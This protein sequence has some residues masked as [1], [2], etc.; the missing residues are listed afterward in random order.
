MMNTS[1][2]LSSRATALAAV[3]KTILPL[4]CAASASAA[5]LNFDFF[6]SGMFDNSGWFVSTLHTPVQGGG[7]TQGTGFK[8][9]GTDTMA[10]SAFYRYDSNQQETVPIFDGDGLGLLWGGAVNGQFNPG[11]IITAPYEFGY[12]FTFTPSYLGDTYISNQWRLTLGLIEWNGENPLNWAIDGGNSGFGSILSQNYVDGGE[13]EAGSYS[14]TGNLDLTVDEWALQNGTPT[15][16][17]VRLEVLVN[18]ENGAN[19]FVTPLRRL[20]GDTLTVTV[21]QNSIDLALISI[22]EPSSIL[23]AA[24]GSMVM[25]RRR[26]NS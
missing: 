12:A 6:G 8:L 21:P 24:A 3:T 5:S 1:P 11:D 7:I 20:N 9:H 2:T 13:S 25:L 15:H 18:H 4:A 16:W 19:D 22:P 23:I 17:F 10:D 26:R 14:R